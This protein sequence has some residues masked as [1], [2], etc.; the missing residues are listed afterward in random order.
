MDTDSRAQ[1]ATLHSDM[2]RAELML[3]HVY[4]T[5][6]TVHYDG[7][8]RLFLLTLTAKTGAAYTGFMHSL[9]GN[10]LISPYLHLRVLAE[11]LALVP[12]LAKDSSG[13]RLLLWAGESARQ[14]VSM[15]RE[16]AMDPGMAA[17]LASSDASEG[18]QQRLDAIQKAD[19]IWRGLH[20]N[21]QQSSRSFLPPIDQR[22]REGDVPARVYP[23][24][25]RFASAWTHLSAS[26]FQATLSLENG[27]PQ[28]DE[29]MPGDTMFLRICAAW[30]YGMLLEKIAPVLGLTPPLDEIEGIIRNVDANW[31]KLDL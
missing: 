13:D 14:D 5:L 1:R 2:T 8:Y 30:L 10:V 22:L 20:P 3:Q 11:A 12:W 28:L 24:V 9:N 16:L 26:S 25:Y 21:T 6:P 7:A 18:H 4:E 17:Y 15:V 31:T 23:M 29:R 19:A 27:G